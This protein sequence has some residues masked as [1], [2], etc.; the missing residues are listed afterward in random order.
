MPTLNFEQFDA[1]AYKRWEESKWL[2]GLKIDD[3]VIIDKHGTVVP[4]PLYDEM[5]LSDLFA[6]YI[7]NATDM[8]EGRIR[9][10]N[11]LEDDHS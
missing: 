6:L 8:A 10:L 1:V 11:I 2:F 5:D 9:D 7:P 4:G 3:L